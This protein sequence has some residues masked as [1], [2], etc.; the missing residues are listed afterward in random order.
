MERCS[1]CEVTINYNDAVLQCDACKL[2]C[3]QAC[4]NGDN[5]MFYRIHYTMRW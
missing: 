1:K 4:I 2:W 3:C 5:P